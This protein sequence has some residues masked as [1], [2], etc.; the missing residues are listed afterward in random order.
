MSGTHI[1]WWTALIVV[2]ALVPVAVSLL[3]RT[4]RAALS[5]RRYLAEMEAAGARIAANTRATAALADTRETA[6]R[7]GTTAGALERGAGELTATLAG[8]ADA[9]GGR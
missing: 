1:A 7:L 9:A 5:I 2:M 8:R 4:L 6:G 3:H